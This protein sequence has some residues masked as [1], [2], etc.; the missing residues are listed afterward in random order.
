M[1]RASILF[2]LLFAAPALSAPLLAGGSAD[3][4]RVKV[5][6]DFGP[7]DRKKV[8]KEVVLKAGAT[9]TDAT[10]AVAELKQGFVCCDAKDVEGI[11]G[12]R[13]DPKKGGWWLYEVNGKKGNLP[14]HRFQLRDGD[15][16]VWRYR[17]L[18]KVEAGRFGS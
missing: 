12:V 6:L 14:A 2:L 9:V 10:R 7:A 15:R 5:E 4:I 16:L 13:C 1:L 18:R 3:G 8:K 11:D 17:V